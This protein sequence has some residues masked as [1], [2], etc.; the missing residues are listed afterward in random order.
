M[1]DSGVRQ[2]INHFLAK[3]AEF[4]A[5]VAEHSRQAWLE[6]QELSGVTKLLDGQQRAWQGIA[7][8]RAALL[9]G[10]PGTGKTFVLSA[11]TVGYLRARQAQ[12][13]P[14]RVFVTAFT[15]NAV[16]NVLNAV[17]R[18]TGPGPVFF[19]GKQAPEDLAGDVEALDHKTVKP[20][21]AEWFV[22]GGT[23]W[24]LFKRLKRGDAPRFDLVCVDEAS[25]ML[26]SHGLLGLGGLANDGRVLV[27]GDDRQ[28][29]PIR[30]SQDE[31]LD[32]RR[33]T[34]SLYAFLKKAEIPEFPLD[35]T[36]R[37]NAPLAAFPAQSFYQSNYKASE[38]SGQQRLELRGDWRE[39]LAPWE[40]AVLDPEHPIV[41]LLHDGPPNGTLN[42][43]EVDLAGH[44]ARLFHRYLDHDQFWQDRFAIITP[45]R[46]QNAA[47]RRSF[48]N[49]TLSEGC[50]VETVER[51]QGKERDTILACYTVSDPEFALSEAEFLFNPQRLNVMITRAKT[52]LVVIASNRLLEVV[53][54]DEELFEHAQ[55]LREFL[56]DTHKI[57]AVERQ[58]DGRGVE[59]TIRVKTFGQAP[60][61]LQPVEVSAVEDPPELTRELEELFGAIKACALES[62]YGNA[63]V[64]AVR[65]KLA[66]Q[67]PFALFHQLLTLGM[68]EFAEQTGPHGRFWCFKPIEP[69]SLPFTADEVTVRSRIDEVIHSR[70]RGRFAPQYRHLRN[71]FVWV[72]AQEQDVLL[73]LLRDLVK[74]GLLVETSHNDEPTF[75]LTSATEVNEQPLP[76]PEVQLTD[77]DFEVL[78]ALEDIERGRIN[79]GVTES[80][81]MLSTLAER[82]GVARDA[83]LEPINRLEQ[84][85]HLMPDEQ[86]GVRSRMAELARELRYVKQRFRKG[87]AHRRPYLVRSLKLETIDRQKPIR[88]V[89]LRATLEQARGLL[90]DDPNLELA[91]EACAHMLS[92]CWGVDNPTIAGFQQRAL[93]S[94]LSAWLGVGKEEAFV[95]TADTGSG[96][97]EAACL[98]ML[99]GAAVDALRGVR[100]CRA[101]LVY[102]RIRLGANQAQRLV[103]Y[104][105]A[106]NQHPGVAPLT[107]GLQNGSVPS[108][109][110][111]LRSNP[112]KFEEWRAL[113]GGALQFPFF[114]CPE[115]SQ[116]LSLLEGE[117]RGGADRLEC[118]CGWCFLGWI[119]SKEG[120]RQNPPHFFLPV[121]ESLHQWQ[122]DS[123][124]GA[125]FGDTE[126]A[127]ARAV[128]ADEIHLYSH[129]HGA[130][131][132]YALRRLLARLTV[133]GD[134]SPLAIGMSATLSR[135][136]RVWGD[137]CGRQQV[138]ALGPTEEERLVNPRG[139]EY[140]YFVQP[141]VESRGQD[142]AGA[143]TT[144]QCLMCLAHGMR[145]RTGKEGGFRGVVFLDSIDKLKRLHSDY[146][147]A[148]ANKLA[149]LRTELLDDDPATGEPCRACC[150]EP[151]SCDRF[152]EGECWFFAATD[153]A[154]WMA[155]KRYRPG[156]PLT[157]AHRPIFSGTSG[158]T[159]ELLQ[160]SDLIF[161]TSTLEVGYDD[162]DMTLV[163]QHY[164]PGNLASF[165]QR[166]GRGG[167]GADDRPVTGVTL[168]VYSSRDSW[169]F[170]SPRRM[171]DARNFAVPLNIS[172]YFVVR[173]QA[174]ATA[175]DAVAR[176]RTLHPGK[177][178]LRRT[179]GKLEVAPQ[180][181]T[182]ADEMVVAACGPTVFAILGL[183]SS[184]PLFQQLLEEEGLDVTAEPSTW[185]GS[186]AWVPQR[187]FDSI[188][189]PLL[190]VRHPDARDPV[191]VD[192]TLAFTE[193]APG[194][195]TR[196]YGM[197]TVHWVPPTPGRSP[198]LS[199]YRD[200]TGFTLTGQ[201]Q[202]GEDFRREL[203][204]EVRDGLGAEIYPKICRPKTLD[205]DLGGKM[206]GA[207]FT[208]GWLYR[209]GHGLIKRD[210]QQ[211]EPGLPATEKSR[212]FLRGFL[213]VAAEDGRGSDITPTDLSD[214]FEKVEAF[215]GSSDRPGT[216]LRVT[217]L[218]WGADV[219]L[220]LKDTK[221]QDAEFTQTFVYPKTDKTLLHG[222]QVET[223]GVRFHVDSAKLDAR[224]DAMLEHLQAN[225]GEE[226]HY[227][228]KLL[229]YL[230]ESRLSGLGV[231]SFEANRL[232]E[233]FV[234]AAASDEGK[235]VLRGRW[236]QTRM[237]NLLRE[238]YR[239]V[240]RYH[241]LL[242][243]R[244]IDKLEKVLE[245]AGFADTFRKIVTDVS[246]AEV[247]RGYLRSLFLHGLAMRLRDLF[248]LYGRGDERRVLFHARLPLQF[249]AES[250]DIISVV[251][252]GDHGDGTTRTFLES[253]E[254][255]LDE[256]RDHGLVDCPNAREDAAVD[257][258]LAMSEQHERWRSLDRAALV[259][260]LRT[261]LSVDGDLGRLV[262]L[263]HGRETVGVEQFDFFDL[264]REVR[265]VEAE[266]AQSMPRAPSTWE[267]VTGAVKAAQ[268]G[269]SPQLAG[270]LAAY[271]GLEGVSHEAG[272]S[273]EERLAEQVFRFAGRLCPDGCEAC[274][275]GSSDLMS[276]TQARA[277]LSRRAL[278]EPADLAC[279]KPETP[280]T[281]KALAKCPDVRPKGWDRRVLDALPARG[282]GED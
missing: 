266:L 79:F 177:Y 256:V 107:I 143:S 13:R 19:L 156:D 185:R 254:E 230:M 44:L 125:I 148:E 279:L 131:V 34:G 242:T 89:S 48:E 134:E 153:Q 155:G 278:M 56:F 92:V 204:V 245:R 159:E 163:Y 195:M 139:R 37:L 26:L 241:P 249:G 244:R 95:V 132:G 145:R 274:L 151:L 4:A 33:L 17:V 200:S 73:P 81:V 114:S 31:E 36:F 112:D 100:G 248:V 63:T 231:N 47:I 24:S 61:E 228:G 271:R 55:L 75:D 164:A 64:S 209:E 53:P 137:L 175:L 257:R 220:K 85:G 161:A 186:L 147:D 15:R 11:M 58:C 217:R 113:P 262:Q 162:P 93:L 6:G 42:P 103:R 86:G 192:I 252:N 110:G 174:A 198:F 221:T 5:Q 259:E 102:P 14:C 83:L 111:Y 165:I 74:E 66:Y 45:H 202:S 40:C 246:D 82:L 119:G 239:N 43:F 150:R 71:S 251:E 97:T 261:E 179:S 98:P 138:V 182:M 183:E 146:S 52:K 152:R 65:K 213:V 46:A 70:R 77:G 281:G 205:L 172:N 212:S 189:L 272:M 282:S 91:L 264:V 277:A 169:Y 123:R 90:A 234:S 118:A 109:F 141:E 196:R 158:R 67:P 168:S 173:G 59:V 199:D 188:N 267:L 160:N 269:R 94:I 54:P 238:T 51:I 108:A 157:V 3:P 276:G 253:F 178:G 275:F 21:E 170:R 240:L 270:L 39:A 247:F 106:F 130:Q 268:D 84:H 128:M 206:S 237:M 224:V 12:N 28:L 133:N 18:R 99:V 127:P 105:A 154:Q 76:P 72:N 211:Q 166:K 41:V 29:A 180:L 115:C 104:L 30:A 167:R 27:V 122:H 124:Y 176:F 2:Q 16:V 78:N 38:Q 1:I 8:H 190:M 149:A 218:Y 57:G 32:E 273:P 10:P 60:E 96:K 80:W 233:L 184:L 117:G 116:D 194:N 236:D 258:M 62:R 136:D 121:T 101:I 140:F 87:D 9:L 243:E 68:I 7:N 50:V 255:A 280:P 120:L 193:C 232:A 203:P 35:E 142:I 214:L 207:S 265:A 23:V 144:I 181:V 135:P 187:L 126:F 49:S 69:P 225:P 129:V 22:A 208:S 88:D 229:A 215:V 25:Q 226:R 171:L 210:K 223:E 227:R 216:G 20:L 222:Y 250:H 260:A 263:L 201:E 235:K 219:S 197:G 191:P